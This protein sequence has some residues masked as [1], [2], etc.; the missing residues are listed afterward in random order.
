QGVL[1]GSANLISEKEQFVRLWSHECLRIF[2]DRLVDDS[3]R[4][5]FNHMLEEKVKA[6]FGLEYENRVRGKNEVLLYGNF[7]DPKGG[8]VYQ[9]ME[10][11]ETLVKT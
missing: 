10:D 5:W 8:K 7:S 4:V 6:H 11:Q 3:D 2:H 1:Q 9:E